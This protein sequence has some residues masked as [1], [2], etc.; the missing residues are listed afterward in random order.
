MTDVQG[1]ADNEVL[2]AARGDQTTI[3]TIATS[4]GRP[5]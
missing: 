4:D 2:K 5:G 1:W 3:R